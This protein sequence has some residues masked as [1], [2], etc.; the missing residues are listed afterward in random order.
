MLRRGKSATKVVIIVDSVNILLNSCDSERPE[1]D[2]MEFVNHL[3]AHADSDEQI[4]IA[5]GANR[6]LLE[7]G[8]LSEVFY[9][10]MKHQMGLFNLVFECSKNRA[11]H[12][13]DVHG[14]LNVILN[15]P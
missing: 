4:S 6:D 10:E 2:L 5:L 12:S 14:Q 1:L 15:G 9:R 13:R 8:S 11:G 3:V 7:S